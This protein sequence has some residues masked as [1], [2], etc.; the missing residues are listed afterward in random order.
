MTTT[1]TTT[2]WLAALAGLL[3]APALLTAC[4]TDAPRAAP[5]PKSDSAADFSSCMRDKGYDVPDPS[6]DQQGLKLQVPDGIDPEQYND[7]LTTCAGADGAGAGNAAR[8]QSV[9]K[10]DPKWKKTVACVRDHGFED[11]PDDPAAD[12][13][14][15]DDAAFIDAMQTCDGGAGSTGLK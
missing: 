6:G 7:D 2:R 4:S 5:S 11:F 10:D 3:L 9:D 1:T 12:Y 15:T 13:E 8:A 14:P